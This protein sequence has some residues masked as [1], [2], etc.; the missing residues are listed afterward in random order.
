MGN[1]SVSSAP[2]VL[3]ITQRVIL[4]S[5]LREPHITTVSAEVAALQ[6]IGNILLDNDSATGSVDE[7]RALLHLGDE[8]LVE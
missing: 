8:L 6:G 7:P 1:H 4:G 2:G 3:G 5:G